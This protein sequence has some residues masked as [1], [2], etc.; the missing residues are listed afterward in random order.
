MTV[1]ITGANGLIGKALNGSLVADGQNVRPLGRRAAVPDGWS[2]DA[3][4]AEPPAGALSGADAVVHL[5]GEPIAQRWTAGAWR[6]IAASRVEGT[7]RL[8]ETLARL[9]HRPS[10]LVSAS[11]TGIY[12]DR[13]DDM[14]TE[15]S[16]PGDGRVARLCQAWEREAMR[17]EDLG[18]RVVLLRTGLVIAPR[19]GF[20]ARMLPAFRMGLGGPLGDGGHWMSWIHLADLIG[21]IRFALENDGVAGPLNATAPEPVENRDFTRSL[22]AALRR[23][24]VLPVPRLALRLLFGE[25]AGILTSSQRV[26]PEKALDHGFRFAFPDLETALDDVLGRPRG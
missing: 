5:L 7:R 19:G 9:E 21:L 17:A 25:M 16:A 8:V 12:G 18:I 14:L 23:P 26:L 24:A 10:V 6:R 4:I 2:W 22:G 20:L 11:A 13:G 3:L 15:I 1:T